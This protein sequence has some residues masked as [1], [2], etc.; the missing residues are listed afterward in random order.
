M[1]PNK[2]LVLLVTGQYIAN[3]GDV[4]YIVGVISILYSLTGSAAISALVP[5]TITMSMFISSLLTPLL[6]GKY[7]LKT[8]LVWSQGLKTI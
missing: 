5:F 4:F 2:N 6:L 3:L 7:R 1:K 8:L